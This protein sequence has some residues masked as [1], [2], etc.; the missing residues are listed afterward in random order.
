LTLRLVVCIRCR[1]QPVQPKGISKTPI[2]TGIMEVSHIPLLSEKNYIS[3][4]KL[5]ECR[6]SIAMPR[7]LPYAG[8]NA[9]AEV[10]IGIN[11]AHGLTEIAAA[12]SDEI[13]A[14]LAADF[15]RYEPMNMIS[16]NVAPAGISTGSN[17]TPNVIGFALS[18]LRN[19][20]TPSRLLRVVANGIAVHQLEYDTWLS[21]KEGALGYITKVLDIIEDSTP[22]FV[23]HFFMRIIDRF[24]FDGE[25]HETD[26]SLLFN[27][28]SQYLTRLSF[29]CGPVWHCNLGWFQA[30]HHQHSVLNA[31]NISSNIIGRVVT[32]NI[33]YNGSVALRQIRQKRKDVMSPASGPGLSE[34]LDWMHQ[35]N[36]MIML[37]LLVSDL[38]GAIGLS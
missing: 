12:H 8:R 18:K 33:D 17:V 13:K 29:S 28:K 30:Q 19:D 31:L 37:D 3:F 6:A 36:K 15:P 4:T 11:Y 35:T 2:H 16:V 25:V 38:A 34:A 26:P 27:R 9:I 7:Y 10:I 5:L 24:T 32:V 22:H 1:S 21:C 20:G 14:A 23:N